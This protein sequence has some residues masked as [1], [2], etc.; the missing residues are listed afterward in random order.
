MNL[1]ALLQAAEDG[2]GVF[3]T[4]LAGEHR[5]ESPLEG[6]VFLDV[7]AILIE[8]RRADGAELSTGKRGLQQV[9]GVHRALRTSRAHEGVELVDEEDD[10]SVGLG[11]LVNYRLEALLE[12]TA[13]L[14]PRH[15]RAEVELEDALVFEGIGHVA[16]DHPLGEPLDDGRL[17]HARITDED[18]VVLGASGEHLHDAADL[19][20]TADDRVE[21]VAAGETGEVAAVLVE[22]LVAALGILIGHALV[23]PDGLKRLEYLVF[24]EAFVFEKP[25]E[26][27]VL[28]EHRKENV[29]GARVVV[30]EL[31][32]L[33]FGLREHAAGGLGEVHL[34]RIP[35]DLGLSL[36]DRLDAGFDL[37][38]RDAE[39]VEKRR[40]DAV[41]LA[42]HGQRE[43]LRLESGMVVFV[44]EARCVLYDRLS[45][46]GKLIVVHQLP[47]D[48]SV[49]WRNGCA[50]HNI[51]PAGYV[52]KPVAAG[53]RV[54][55][56][57]TQ[58]RLIAAPAVRTM[59]A[60][61]TSWATSQQSRSS[62]PS[63]TTKSSS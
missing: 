56:P 53:R 39:T 48:E 15:Q 30:L 49:D 24:G 19:L 42:H 5:L 52:G 6:S 16:A 50:G 35:V 27:G 63:S 20:V 32:R 23:S 62:P 2:H 14:R 57:V 3:N 36:E 38:R 47:S 11:D 13:E 59:C 44:Y 55:A 41:G 40:H 29:L 21:L 37:V 43:M 4:R 61:V 34:L 7:L 45:L 54:A 18:G 25:P 51:S 58:G 9:G 12:L 31:S 46:H 10:L 1:V 60:E 17:S 26:L 22:H 28:H 33:L 8:C